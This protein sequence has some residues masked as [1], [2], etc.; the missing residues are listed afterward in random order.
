MTESN[1]S[2]QRFPKRPIT[3]HGPL[4]KYGACYEFGGRTPRQLIKMFLVN[5]PKAYED[6]RDHAWEVVVGSVD[7]GMRLGADQLDVHLGNQGIHLVP[8]CRT[9]SPEMKIQGAGGRGGGKAIMGAALIATAIVLAPE[10]GVAAGP[11]L[12]GT[13]GYAVG[14]MGS[15]A[16]SLG[17]LGSVSYSQIAMFGVSM[18][19]SGA[20][21]M[22]SSAASAGDTTTQSADT[23]AS[24]LFNGIQNTSAQGA[25][26]PLVYGKCMTG[27]VLVSA[28]L[29][30]EAA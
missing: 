28:G 15:T 10:A 24:Y 8:V 21:S 26:V 7:G 16:F 20:A 23:N 22:L 30:T 12:D 3:L 17:A 19:L 2:F 25:A 5:F 18:A 11:M 6:I 13:A 27:S 29:S 1:T 14:G 4:T 9:D